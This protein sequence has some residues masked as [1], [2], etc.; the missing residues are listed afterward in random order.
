M[1]ENIYSYDPIV[2]LAIVAVALFGKGA[3]VHLI[4]AIHYRTRFFMAFTIGA[5]SSF[6]YHHTSKASNN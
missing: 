5:F 3:I 1:T 4:Q 6:S 2:P